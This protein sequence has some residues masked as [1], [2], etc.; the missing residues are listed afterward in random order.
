LISKLPVDVIIFKEEVSENDNTLDER[1]EEIIMIN[2]NTPLCGQCA[3]ADHDHTKKERSSAT[4]YGYKLL[5]LCRFRK[6]YVWERDTCGRYV[7]EDSNRGR[8]IWHTWRYGS[9]D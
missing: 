4:P 3:W 5:L 2:G 1:K 7:Y 6:V 9:P 8:E